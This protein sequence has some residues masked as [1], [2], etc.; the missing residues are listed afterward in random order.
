MTDTRRNNLD[1]VRGFFR[2]HHFQFNE[3]GNEYTLLTAFSGISF[4]IRH[5]EP[6]IALVCT[7][8]ADDITADRF[9][10]VLEWVET[11]NNSHAFPTAAA[12]KDEPRNL[13]ALG[14]TFV[15]PGQWEY[16]DEQFA[17][18]LSSGIHGVV[19]AATSFLAE[20][21]P[22]ALAQVRQGQA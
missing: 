20:F 19:D 7:V 3:T 10:N 4:E 14:A 1:R 15:I 5:L 11:Y 13:T 9:E 17:D 6:N 8:A 18:W 2:D 12:L 21:S 16:T 22:A